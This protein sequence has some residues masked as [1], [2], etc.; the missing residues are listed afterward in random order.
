MAATRD[1]YEIL[2]VT[3][4]A[5]TDDIRKAYRKLA[6]EHHPDVSGAPEAEQRFK[7]ISGAYEILSDPSKRQQ[8]DTFGN[9]GGPQAFPFGDVGDIFDIFFGGG[10]G[11]GGGGFGTRRRTR[12][13]RTRTERGEDLFVTLSLGFTEAV[14]GLQREVPVEALEVCA[15]CGGTGSRPETTP[16]QCRTCGGAGE[17][18]DMRRSIFGTVMTSR[19]CP[20]C[21]GTGEEITDPCNVC[22]GQGRVIGRRTIP[23]EVPPGVSDGLEMRMSGAGHAGRM[24]GAPGDLYVSFRVESHPVFE[25]RGTDLFAVLDVPLSRAALGA[26]L[27]VETLDGAERVRVDAGT[28][29]GAVLRVKGKG[30]P[31]LGRRGR[32]DLFLTV[33]VETPKRLN[34]EERKL[35][36]RLGELRGES[37]GEDAHGVLRHPG[38]L[39]PPAG[40]R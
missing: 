12:P 17:V 35:L 7:E 37:G 33:Q 22:G 5:T 31:N 16:T 29:S 18:Q 15:T 8:Y 38:T 25:R 27:E 28:E 40:M 11:G 24:G 3:R 9:A 34:K 39:P 2:G 32:G 23:V 21:E 10:T 1:L 6:R 36:E 20:T 26:E 19:P 13:R 14:F 30:V 4:D